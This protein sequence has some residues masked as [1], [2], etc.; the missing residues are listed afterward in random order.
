MNIHTWFQQDTSSTDTHEV[1]RKLRP[2]KRKKKLHTADHDKRFLL[3]DGVWLTSLL[4]LA[5]ALERMSKSVFTHHVG[6]D[7][8]HFAQWIENVLDDAL[9]A[10]ELLRE[11]NR[12]GAL[13]VVLK[14]IKKYDV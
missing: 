10:E 9:C 1:V 6:D 7:H 14:H 13:R 3:V 8:N 4:D 5:S 11:K 2:V 12:A